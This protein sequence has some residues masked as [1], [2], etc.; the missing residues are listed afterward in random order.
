MVEFAEHEIVWEIGLDDEPHAQEHESPWRNGW[1]G[2]NGPATC[3]TTRKT[4]AGR[5]PECHSHGLEARGTSWAGCPWHGEHG[6]D[7]RATFG[8]GVTGGEGTP[9]TPTAV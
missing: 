7:A 4:D 1:F 9:K 2:D 8:V 6:Q 5:P 3:G